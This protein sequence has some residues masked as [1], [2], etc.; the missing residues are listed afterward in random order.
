MNEWADQH[1]NTVLGRVFKC[2]RCRR[3]VTLC[4][5]LTMVSC[6]RG[7]K[8]QWSF[9]WLEPT[10]CCGHGTVD[11]PQMVQDLAGQQV[12]QV[13]LTTEACCTVVLTV[14]GEVWTFQW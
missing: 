10:Q 13:A 1:G 9:P 5:A 8:F 12:V 3:D 14:R 11:I 7:G 6:T 4:H 2:E